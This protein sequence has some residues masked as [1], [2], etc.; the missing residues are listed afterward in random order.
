M[1]IGL[2]DWAFRA[3]RLKLARTVSS[4]LLQTFF[5]HC[6]AGFHGLLVAGGGVVKGA[7]S[8]LMALLRSRRGGISGGLEPILSLL[9]L[10]GQFLDFQELL[11]IL[12]QCEGPLSLGP[13]VLASKA[14]VLHYGHRMS[15]WILKGTALVSIWIRAM[16]CRF[17][18]HR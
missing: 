7:V 12:L 14:G 10:R 11:L 17:Q 16:S 13:K 1:G 4:E 6:I 2:V 5:R 8:A 9:L 18:I 15:I 3:H